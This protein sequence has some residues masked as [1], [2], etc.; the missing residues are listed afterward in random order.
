MLVH[1]AYLRFAG[2][3][4]ALAEDRQHFLAYA[5]SVMRSVVI[6]VIR[7]ERA[8]K[9]G[10]GEQA[11][12]LNTD[13]IDFESSTNEEALRI[14]EAL[15]ELGAIDPRL[16]QIVEMRFFAGLTDADIAGALD[17]SPRTVQRYWQK[18][19]LFL[20]AQLN[21]ASAGAQPP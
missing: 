15:L 10:G 11:L 9:R 20:Y 5:S 18:A 8:R 16:V 3:G 12:T 4:D 19:R 6:D 17:L 2:A 7:A 1:E 21:E 14:H 13:I